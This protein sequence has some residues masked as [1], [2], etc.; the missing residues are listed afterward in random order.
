MEA[1]ILADKFAEK[2]EGDS[3]WNFRGDKIRWVT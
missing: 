3:N 2:V 1:V